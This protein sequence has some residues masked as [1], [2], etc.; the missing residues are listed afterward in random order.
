MN[1][2]DKNNKEYYQIGEA[3]K[4]GNISRRALRYYETLGLLLPDF[5][6]DNGYRYYS[7]HSILKISIIKYLKIMDFSLDEI[8]NHLNGMCY[9]NMINNFNYLIAKC[10]ECLDDIFDRKTI[11]DDWKYCLEEACLVLA[12]KIDTVNVKYMEEKQ[13]IKYPMK[14][15][16]DYKSAILDLGFVQFVEKRQ[17]KITG[18]V[19]FYFPSIH[20]R[21]ENTN[22]I[23]DGL[24]IQKYV[25]K[26]NEEDLHVVEAGMYA[27]KYHIGSHSTIL[28]SY[29]DLLEWEKTSNYEI[30]G[31]VIERFVADY[32]SSWDESTYV[33]ELMAQVR[34]K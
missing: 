3:A 11:I 27:N 10:D 25:K 29:R 24:Y 14:F 26:V 33:T 9:E 16:H 19:M 28:D 6:D 8:R 34:L 2:S 21:V 22:E 15:N 18:P 1:C 31:P 13:L 32:W 23:I 12:M 17:N 5:I 4:L 7:K 20:K 30:V